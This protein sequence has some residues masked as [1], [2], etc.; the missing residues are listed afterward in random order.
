[1]PISLACGQ[2]Y[3]DLITPQAECGGGRGGCEADRN[4]QTRQGER[5]REHARPAGQLGCTINTDLYTCYG[6][7]KPTWK[8]SACMYVCSLL[9]QI[10]RGLI[11]KHNSKAYEF[12]QYVRLH[13]PDETRVWFIT[14][15]L[16]FASVHVCLCSPDARTVYVYTQPEVTNGEQGGNGPGSSGC[17]VISSRL[18]Q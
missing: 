7:G 11:L 1:M 4:R 18:T 3:T 15:N 2:A 17:S 14:C 10:S 12:V 9:S 6:R 8:Y 13:A 5:G 16:A